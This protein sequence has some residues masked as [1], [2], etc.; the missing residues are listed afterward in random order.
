MLGLAH[1]ARLRRTR[2]HRLDA[3]ALYRNA[4]AAFDDD[5]GASYTIGKWNARQAPWTVTRATLRLAITRLS[6]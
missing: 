1:A 5:Y 3:I 6:R 4:L 2:G